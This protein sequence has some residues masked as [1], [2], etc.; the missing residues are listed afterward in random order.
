[1]QLHY[2]SSI[3]RVEILYTL[4]VRDRDDL[5]FNDCMLIYISLVSDID[6]MQ[7]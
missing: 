7:N 6:K 3:Y 5:V 2:I 1:M 4:W